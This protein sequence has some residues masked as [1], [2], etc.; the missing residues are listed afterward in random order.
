MRLPLHQVGEGQ[1]WPAELFIQPDTKV[2]Q[3]NLRRQTDSKPTEIMRPLPVQ[4]EGM[5]E[6]VVH[7]F[8]DLPEPGQPAPQGL[9]PW[10]LAIPLGRTE[11]LGPR[12]LPPRHMIRLPFKALIDDIRPQSRAP[13]TGQP[14]M[15]P[16]AQGKEGLRQRLI[17]GTGGSK[18]KA[19]IH[20]NGVHRQ[21]EMESFIPAQSVTPTDI[22]QPRQPSGPPT[23]GIPRGNARTVQCFIRTALAGQKLDQ[24]QTT[25]YQRVMMLAHL[26]MKLLPGRQLRKGHPQVVLRIAVKPPLAP[27]ALPWPEDC[28]CQYLTAT[29]GSRGARLALD[30]QGG[31]AEIIHHH[32]KSSQEG[33]SI[34]HSVAPIL[35]KIEQ[36]YRSEAPSVQPSVGNSH[37][38][39]KW[40][41]GNRARAYLA[42]YT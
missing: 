2:M 4:T 30:R 8:N 1:P 34:D 41:Q 36:F 7:C 22:G 25:G 35:G 13:Y 31:L 5:L 27:K 10:R 3:G 32:V 6:L 17:F 24:K 19:G 42:V 26:P 11:H 37:Q 28:Q 40:R 18:A 15:R 14:R 23:F 21:Q 16:T 38:A 9:W 33:V 12:G 20:P 29:E 39:F